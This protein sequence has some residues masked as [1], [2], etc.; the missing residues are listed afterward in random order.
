MKKENNKNTY[1][2]VDAAEWLAFRGKEPT[3][4]QKQNWNQEIADVS[5]TLLA[6]LCSPKIIVKGRKEP[7]AEL[8][9]ITVQAGCQLDFGN[10]IIVSENKD[11]VADIQIDPATFRRFFLANPEYNSPYMSPY[12]EIMFEVI[13][14]MG[15]TEDNQPTIDQMIP[16]VRDRLVARNRTDSDNQIMRICRVIR[17]PE[18]QKGGNRPWR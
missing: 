8:E 3:V 15:I 12:M 16:V 2:L 11:I 1:S 10:N 14:E 18:A 5:E 7:G 13:A 6:A 9:T 4:A 17:M